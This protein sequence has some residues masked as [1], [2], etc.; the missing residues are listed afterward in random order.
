[1]ELTCLVKLIENTEKMQ[2]SLKKTQ[3]IHFL[4]LFLQFNNNCEF[5]IYKNHKLCIKFIN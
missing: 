3:K 5:E 2:K 4:G 1:M